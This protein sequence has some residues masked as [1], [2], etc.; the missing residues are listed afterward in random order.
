[1]ISAGGI[2]TGKVTVSALGSSQSDSEDNNT[3]TQHNDAYTH[4]IVMHM[5]TMY[6]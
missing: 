3:H 1:M 5:H 6:E 2:K 4:N